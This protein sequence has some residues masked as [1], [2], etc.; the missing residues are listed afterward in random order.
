MKRFQR[1]SF[2]LLTIFL[3]VA[4]AA[5]SASH[6]ALMRRMREVRAAA[7][8]EV[9]AARAQ[10]DAA[11][12]ELELVRK[13]Y[14][15]LK[16][17]DPKRIYITRIEGEAGHRPYR[18]HIPAGTHLMLH[19]TDTN[20]SP[21]GEPESWKPTKTKSMNSWTDGADVILK[22]TLPPEDDGTRRLKVVTDSEDL[23]DYRLEGWEEPE[24]G[25]PTSGYDVATDAQSS[26]SPGETICLMKFWNDVNKRGVMLWMEP[27]AQWQANRGQ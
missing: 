24:P 20:F 19:I 25:N 26:F 16:I 17:E 10:V 6:V 9:A 5:L 14:G 11:N 4:I 13:E 22:W 12:A 7:A 2:S 1:F 15:Y 3:L 23:F 18:M 27:F 21:R 8:A